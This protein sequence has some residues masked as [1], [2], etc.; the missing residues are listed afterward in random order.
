MLNKKLE[1]KDA[2]R[3][4]DSLSFYKVVRVAREKGYLPWIWVFNSSSL[5]EFEFWRKCLLY[6]IERYVR[7]KQRI[8][9]ICLGNWA[10]PSNVACKYIN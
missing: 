3:L 2:A 6:Y 10:F 7:Y 1:V 5:F 9:L 4:E 8:L